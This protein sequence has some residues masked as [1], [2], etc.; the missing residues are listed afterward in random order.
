M[1]SLGLQRGLALKSTER[2]LYPRLVHLRSSR[3]FRGLT[4]PGIIRVGLR[5]GAPPEI[6]ERMEG[7]GWT[8]GVYHAVVVVGSAPQWRWIEVADPSYGREKWPIQ[9]EEDLSY[10]WDG[11]VLVLAPKD[12]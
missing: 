8:P 12:A 9:K 1:P 11:R 5:P 7:F 3:G 4:G 10:L 6:A 2:N